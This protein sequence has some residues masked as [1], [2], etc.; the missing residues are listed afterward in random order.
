MQSILIKVIHHRNSACETCL[1]SNG[2]FQLHRKF[3]VLSIPKERG[4]QYANY[5]YEVRIGNCNIEAGVI[6]VFSSEAMKKTLY[7]PEFLRFYQLAKQPATHL[8]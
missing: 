7:P 2:N 3:P 5:R 8:P 4:T 1:D 6:S